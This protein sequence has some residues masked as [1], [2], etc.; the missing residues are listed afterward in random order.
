MVFRKSPI[1]WEKDTIKKMINLYCRERHHVK[2]GLCDD[3]R[4]LMVYAL[5][6]LDSCGFGGNKP[7][8][9]K[10]PVHCF[11]PDMRER[12]KKVMR[13]AG[14]R[15]IIYHPLE[16]ILYI[17]KTKIIERRNTNPDRAV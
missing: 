3:C 12:V 10:C 9:K 11:K 4:E 17:I 13:H 14:P 8:C 15:M 7:T 1:E 16:A 5:K 2:Q 6:R